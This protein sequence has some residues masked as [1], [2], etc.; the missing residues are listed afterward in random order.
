MDIYLSS[1]ILARWI[2]SKSHPW[3]SMDYPGL[4]PSLSNTDSY[5]TNNNLSYRSDSYT[6][7]Y[8]LDLGKE[9]DKALERTTNNIFGGLDII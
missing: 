4:I 1:L 7:L 9:K 5:Y 2:T 3:I 8:I 6:P